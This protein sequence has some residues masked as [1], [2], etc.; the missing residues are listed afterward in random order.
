MGNN[1]TTA[2]RVATTACG[3]HTCQ[4]LPILEAVGFDPRRQHQRSTF[5]YVFV[6]ASIVVAAALLTWAL[7]G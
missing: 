6:A 2:L 3:C 1:H 4:R 5:D 7:L